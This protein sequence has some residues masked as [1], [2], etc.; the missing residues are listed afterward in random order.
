MVL[1]C[2]VDGLDGVDKSKE[3]SEFNGQQRIKG[4]NGQSSGWDEVNG[5]LPYLDY[6]IFA[7]SPKIF[8]LLLC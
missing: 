6:D 2:E 7:S 8:C 1:V 4:Y 5:I 3:T